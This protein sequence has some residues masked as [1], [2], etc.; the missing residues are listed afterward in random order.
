[1]ALNSFGCKAGGKQAEFKGLKLKV[2]L[3]LFRV[4]D[5]IKVPGFFWGY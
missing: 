1:M 3:C 5:R 2:F 4:Q